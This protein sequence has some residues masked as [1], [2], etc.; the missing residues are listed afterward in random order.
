VSVIR[1]HDGKLPNNKYIMLKRY[2]IFDERQTQ[3]VVESK[4]LISQVND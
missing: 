2:R 1:E 3:V 4:K